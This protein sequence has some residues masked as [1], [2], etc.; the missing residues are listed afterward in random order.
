M[1]MRLQT[2]THLAAL[3][4][5]LHTVCVSSLGHWLEKLRV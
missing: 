3:E 2:K 5:L 1:A 4:T